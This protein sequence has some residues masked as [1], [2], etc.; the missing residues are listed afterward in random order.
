MNR[1]R[2]VAILAAL[3]LFGAGRS[4]ADSWR[5]DFSTDWFSQFA[6]ADFDG[7]PGPTENALFPATFPGSPLATTGVQLSAST[8]V[9]VFSLDSPL[10]AQYTFTGS[11]GAVLTATELTQF[12]NSD[13]QSLNVSTFSSMGLNTPRV[14][15]INN[16][17]VALDDSTVTTDL[18]VV[19]SNGRLDVNDG[20]SV[21]TGR[22][23]FNTAA[24]AIRVNSG[25]ELRVEGDTTLGRGTTT[26][27]AGG[28]LNALPGVDLAYDGT[29]LLQFFSGHAVDSGVHLAAVGGGDITST[30][31]IDVGNGNASF[32][33]VTGSGSTLTAGGST[34]DWGLGPSGNASVAIA[35]SALATVNSLRAGTSDARFVATVS[36]GATLRTTSTTSSFS[37]GGGATLRQ[38]SLD[39][40]GGTFEADG[41]ATFNNLAD[42]NLVSGTVNFD[43]GATF[44]AGS[45]MDWTGGSVNLGAGKTLLIDGGAVIKTNMTGFIFSGNS[46]TRIRSG[47]GFSTPSYFDL[48]D[49]T[50]DMDNGTLSVGTA[51]GSVSDWG[52]GTSTTATL[53]NN[54][55]ATYNSGLQ[56]SLTSSGT[57]NATISGG[58]RLV[59]SFLNTGGGATTNVTLN[60]NG[61][62]IESSGDLNLL[63]GTTAAVTASGRI[64][65]QDIVLGSSGGSTSLSVTGGG[66]VLDAND[67]LVA[68]REGTATLTISGGADA[69]VTTRTVIGELAGANGTVT[70]SG[71]GSTLLAGSSLKVG[72]AGTGRLNITSAGFVGVSGGVTLNASSKLDLDVSGSLEIP[73]SS[74]IANGGEI[75]LTGS[76]QIRGDI[77]NAGLLRLFDSSVTR[78]V[79][80]AAGSHMFA[81]N[82]SVAS[83][84]QEA[85]AEMHFQLRGASNFDNL[86]ATGAATLGGELMVALGGGFM[87]ALGAEFMILSAGSVGGTFAVKDF[88]SAPLGSGLAWDVLYTPNS[89]TLKVVAGISGDYNKNGTVD[90]ADYVVWRKSDGSAAGY[91]LW[92]TNFGNPPSAGTGAAESSSNL[93]V[94]PEPE[95]FVLLMI[96][97]AGWRPRQRRDS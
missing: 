15:I 92:R 82:S 83:L 47:G 91:N 4:R 37:M 64:E 45:R 54:A 62:R 79:T 6:W 24:G 81:D 31:F 9:K 3:V 50:L 20:S 23:N 18:L 1:S 87:P 75:E 63:R 39:V 49:A 77:S 85:G 35:D 65:G 90:A 12:F 11:N 86:S 60:V 25:G 67:V 73:V 30:S 36:S 78:G 2:A 13:S 26:I 52:A 88:S 69:D 43:G 70:V 48:G 34:S 58:A 14:D 28:Q 56:M 10:N 93:V 72:D 21:R 59:T 51:G 7:P 16:A 84:V 38:V 8:I 95:T 32:L 40:I 89:V 29:A 97:A 46:T 55:V 41:V 94:V 5:G 80:L 68:G 61:G 22:Y 33:T 71:L 53:S 17:I 96:A 66:A 19:D 44:S 76:S 74:S 57:T 27:D 42:L